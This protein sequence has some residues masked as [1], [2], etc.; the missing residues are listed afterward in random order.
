MK[1]VIAMAGLVL[2]L[3][4]TTVF[5]QGYTQGRSRWAAGPEARTE[6]PWDGEYRGFCYSGR[7]QTCS[8]IFKRATEQDISTECSQMGWRRYYAFQRGR[9]ATD[10]RRQYCM[11]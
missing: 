6:A 5:A 7:N 8:S 2:A 4:A 9:E 3:T 10:A 11:N 1:K